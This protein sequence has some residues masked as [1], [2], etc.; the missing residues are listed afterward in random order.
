MGESGKE[1]DLTFISRNI[2]HIKERID[3]AA[4][5]SGRTGQDVRLV[6]VGKTQP[7]E[8][9]RAVID[10]GVNDIGENR[11][12]ELMAKINDIP[13]VDWHFIGSLQRNKVRNV[14]G[15]VKLIQSV[16]RFDLAH[17]I[18]RRAAALGLVQ[19]VLVQ[20]NVSGEA[21]K[22]GITLKKL[23]KLVA[24]IG[25]LRHIRVEGLMTMGLLGQP[26]ETR[27]VFAGLKAAFD[28]LAKNQALTWLSMGM[29]DD[30]E[31]AIEEGSNLVRI[32]RAVFSRSQ[33]VA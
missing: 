17:D 8:K 30:F 6:V 33:G 7:V 15:R 22:Q 4:R 19:P 20:V 13:P 14:V 27:L 21:T 10:A 25:K 32:G 26:T 28:G 23:D 31:A 16:D 12:Q 18:D 2:A 24:E 9:L 3:K 5:R 29:T 11:V 1:A